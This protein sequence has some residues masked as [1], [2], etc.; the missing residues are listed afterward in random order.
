[1]AKALIALVAVGALALGVVAVS[2]SVLGAVP[3]ANSVGNR[4]D[5]AASCNEDGSVDIEVASADSANG[6]S[7]VTTVQ[8]WLEAD[9]CI[10]QIGY[11]RLA[12]DVSG[13][14]ALGATA[15]AP[16]Q[17]YPDGGSV[18]VFDVSSQLLEAADIGF[19]A[20]VV[21]ETPVR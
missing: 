7:K 21:Q 18:V 4:A 14:T 19:A 12:S 2:A 6:H 20:I 17:P 9:A 15:E 1:M 13:R 10:G 3:W 11:L 16:V 5:I 8:V